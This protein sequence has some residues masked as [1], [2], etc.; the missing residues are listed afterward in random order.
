VYAAVGGLLFR[1]LSRED[2]DRLAALVRERSAELEAARTLAEDTN[3]AK[4]LFLA[5][6]SH[7]LRTP[8]HAVLSYA[9]LGRDARNPGEQRDYFE[10][11]AERGNALLHLLSDLLD[12]SRLESGSMSNSGPGA[13]MR[14]VLPLAVSV[15]TRRPVTERGV[16]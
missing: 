1:A 3:R 2:R 7:E 12:L 16:A 6:M 8:M 13:T 15:T 9:Q 4:T 11:I 10:R 5:D 14:V